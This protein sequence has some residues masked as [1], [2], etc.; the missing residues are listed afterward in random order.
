MKIMAWIILSSA[1]VVAGCAWFEDKEARFLHSA[2]GRAT[3]EEVKQELGPPVMTKT[4]ASGHDIWVYQVR[5]QQ[6]GSRINA[7]GTWCDEYVLT[8]DMR[9]VLKDWTHRSYFHGGENNPTY[10]VPGGM[11]G[12][13]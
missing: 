10:C 12:K 3:Q 7:P 13:P 1:M 8:F 5:T 9:A 2:E 11:D 6:P 4:T